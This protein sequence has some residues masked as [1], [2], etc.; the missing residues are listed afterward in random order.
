[1]NTSSQNF[2]HPSRV[3]VAQ[4]VSFPT[5]EMKAKDSM[6]TVCRFYVGLRRK[7]Y[8]LLR[9]R[10][11][12]LRTSFASTSWGSMANIASPQ[13][14]QGL[15]PAERCLR[16]RPRTA[17]LRHGVGDRLSLDLELKNGGLRDNRR[18]NIFKLEALLA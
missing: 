7:R 3:T 4:S 14:E 5:N 11:L 6:S 10:C 13:G 18:T 15:P 12:N 9:M 8:G 16:R 1:M 17:R 2:Q